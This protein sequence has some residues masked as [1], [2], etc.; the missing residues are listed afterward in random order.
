M[1]V[2]IINGSPRKKGTT[3]VIAKAFAGAAAESG[4]DVRTHTL[5]DMRDIRGCQ[6]CAGCFDAGHCVV[7]D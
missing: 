6:S 1:N 2:L 7:E 4:A 3:S 5:Y